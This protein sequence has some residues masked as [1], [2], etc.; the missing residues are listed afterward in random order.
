MAG[1]VGNSQS[2]N[3][4]DTGSGRKVTGQSETGEKT[5]GAELTKREQRS[6][7]WAASG[8]VRGE[9]SSKFTAAGIWP[10]ESSPLLLHL[11]LCRPESSCPFHR[12]KVREREGGRR[13]SSVD[14]ETTKFMVVPHCQHLPSSKRY[15]RL[16][17]RIQTAHT[18][19]SPEQRL[20]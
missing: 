10:T 5:R 7:Q 17:I 11:R 20:A 3:Y 13:S 16:S 1:G 18:Y 4:G 12:G 8:V 14:A 9:K 6:G 15:Q 19:P 2:C